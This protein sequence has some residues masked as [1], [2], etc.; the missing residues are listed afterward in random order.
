MDT[1]LIENF[2]PHSCRS[3]SIAKAF[4]MSFHFMDILR[5]VCW[6]NAETFPQHHKKEIACYEGVDF[7][8]IMEY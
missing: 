5:K 4:N 2:T 8:K 6:R 7:N 1:N 3:A